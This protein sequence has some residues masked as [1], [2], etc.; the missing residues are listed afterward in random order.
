MAA[1]AFDPGYNQEPFKSLCENYPDADVYPADGFRVEWGPIFH[2]GRLDGSARVLLIGQDPAQ[3]ETIIRR[4]LVGE[5]G[6]R[7]QGFLAKLGID[8][9]YVMVNTFLY[10]VYGSVSAKHRKAPALIDYRHRWLKALMLGRQI[11]LV[12]TFG[13]LADEAWNIWTATSDG[14]ALAA[15]HVALT[16]PTQ[17]ESSA[18]GDRDKLGAATKA[19]LKQWN[20]G[21]QR[22]H[23][24]LQHPDSPKPLKLYS[25]SWQPGDKVPIPEGDLPP[26]LPAWMREQDNWARRSGGNPNAKRRNITLTV[27]KGIAP[28][29]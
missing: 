5:A 2:R 9:S 25:E 16:H 12:M 6:Q 19:M 27:P 17:P 1:H 20:E 28:E 11:E 23:S 13:M 8:R 4:I 15:T 29:S 18:K 3:N 10:S 21:L 24:A 14:Q 26:G 22:L 7:V